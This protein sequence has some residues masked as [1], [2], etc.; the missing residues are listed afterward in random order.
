MFVVQKKKKNNKKNKKNTN[1]QTF[2]AQFPLPLREKYFTIYF[3]WYQQ[4]CLS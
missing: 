4:E 1:S 3:L 2:V